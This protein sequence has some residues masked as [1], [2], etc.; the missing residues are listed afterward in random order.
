MTCVGILAETR[1]GFGDESFSP[2]DGSVFL[3]FKYIWIKVG[4]YISSKFGNSWTVFT[5]YNFYRHLHVYKFCFDF[6][7]TKQ[8]QGLG[9]KS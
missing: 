2:F 6:L 3:V 4:L 7:D 9:L 1:W 5:S 8:W